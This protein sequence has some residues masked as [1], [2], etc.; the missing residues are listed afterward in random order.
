MK[1]TGLFEGKEAQ[2]YFESMLESI[3]RSANNSST[4]GRVTLG[5]SMCSGK[6]D[7]TQQC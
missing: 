3:P 1:R 7:R 2:L 5:N 6:N 4:K